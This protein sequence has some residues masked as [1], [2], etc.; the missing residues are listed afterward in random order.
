MIQ[1]GFISI[2]SIHSF[3]HRLSSRR[4][5]RRIRH[6][7]PLCGRFIAIVL[8]RILD[9]HFFLFLW[10]RVRR[11]GCLL[12]FLL[13][14]SLRWLHFLPVVLQNRGGLSSRFLFKLRRNRLYGRFIKEFLGICL[15][16][17]LGICLGL[18]KEIVPVE[19]VGVG[20]L[21]DGRRR[22]KRRLWVGGKRRLWL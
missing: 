13:R 12:R 15:R 10:R 4:I 18:V 9:F 19:V 6:R 14:Q 1:F 20:S 22:I 21:A 3:I 2:S 17:L 5:L 11:I 16:F 7:S 8:P